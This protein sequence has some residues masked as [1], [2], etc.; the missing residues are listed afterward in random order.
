MR[1]YFLCFVWAHRNYQSNFRYSPIFILFCVLNT[2]LF[3]Q[4]LIFLDPHVARPAVPQSLQSTYWETFH[5]TD[6]L[7]VQLNSIDPSCAFGF[8]IRCEND[9]ETLIRDL[10]DVN[11]LKF[12]LLWPLY[13]YHLLKEKT[14]F[15]MEAL[16]NFLTIFF[17]CLSEIYF[18]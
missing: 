4:Y 13:L 12:F 11:C 17:F 14:C 5:C 2:F 9:F 6:V 1:F 7:K 15:L 3:R 8:L 16:W 10:G 18:F